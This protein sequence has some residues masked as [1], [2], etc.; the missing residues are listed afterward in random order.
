MILN[1]GEP[2][3]LANK[4][5]ELSVY[6]IGTHLSKKEWFIILERLMETKIL[7]VGEFSG[8]LEM[9]LVMVQKRKMHIGDV[10][11]ADVA[12][13]YI[14]YIETLGRLPQRQSAEFI[15]VAATL[16]LIK[17]KSLLPGLELSIEEQESIEELE[18]RLG[19]Y[20]IYQ[21]AHEALESHLA[22]CTPLSQPM[23]LPELTAPSQLREG[24][25][26]IAQLKGIIEKLVD[27]LPMQEIKEQTTLIESIDIKEVMCDLLYRLEYGA[28]TNFITIGGGCRHEILI[29]FLALLELVKDGVMLAEQ[30]SEYGEILISRENSVI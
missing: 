9:L 17:S 5:D 29:N 15:V 19:L 6:N 18:H 2:A 21:A 8:S 28:S 11:L 13:E 10:S 20:K 3:L 14:G 30:G 25:I 7:T 24:S 26:T 22:K 23:P 16:L 27:S 4:A 12:D 1:V